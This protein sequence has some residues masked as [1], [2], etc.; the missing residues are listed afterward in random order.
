[1]SIFLG[2]LVVVA[3]GISTIEAVCEKDWP[4]DTIGWFVA[5]SAIFLAW[6]LLI[7]F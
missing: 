7:G 2:A 3:G 1:M 6:V 5:T 4:R